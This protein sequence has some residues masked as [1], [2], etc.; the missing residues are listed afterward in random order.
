MLTRP[1]GRSQG[2]SRIGKMPRPIQHQSSLSSLALQHGVHGPVPRSRQNASVGN[3]GMSLEGQLDNVKPMTKEN[4]V[5]LLPY[6]AERA[7]E[8]VPVQH[9]SRVIQTVPHADSAH[10]LYLSSAW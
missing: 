6:I 9:R 7:Y 8:V 10:L 5:A 2:L 3:F 1:F 4:R